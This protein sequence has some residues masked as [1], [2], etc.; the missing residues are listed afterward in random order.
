MTL[1]GNRPIDTIEAEHFMRKVEQMRRPI[2]DMGCSSGTV[3]DYVDILPEEYLGIDPSQQALALAKA[4][5]PDHLFLESALP[6]TAK[7]LDSQSLWWQHSNA[8]M[9]YFRSMVCLFGAFNFVSGRAIPNLID[10][11]Q[12]MGRGGE[13]LMMLYSERHPLRG[14]NVPEPPLYYNVA[15][16]TRTLR[17]LV[18]LHALRRFKV[19]AYSLYG[20]ELTGLPHWLLALYM[21][22]ETETLARITPDRAWWIVVEAIV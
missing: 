21:Q 3:L 4:K 9:R 13:V 19:R 12:T 2:I 18:R 6:Q 14:I 5:H 7:T 10:M 22:L 8:R 16:V 11:M 15:S 1:Q 17:G 20:D